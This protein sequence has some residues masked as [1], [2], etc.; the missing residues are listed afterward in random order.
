MTAVSVTLSGSRRAPARERAGSGYSLRQRTRTRA[1]SRFAPG[2]AATVTPSRADPYPAP[3]SAA[4][5]AFGELGERIAERWLRR[6]R[7]ARAS[8]RRFRSGHRDIDL[9]VERDGVVAFVEVKARRGDRFGGSGGGGQLA[10][11]EGVGVVRRASGS[12]ATAGRTTPTGSTWSGCSSRASACGSGTSRT[13][14]PLHR[15]GLISGTGLRILFGY[16]VARFSGTLMSAWPEES[17]TN[18]RM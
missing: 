1:A 10:E 18:E 5:Q 17:T 9:V 3:M 13:H 15:F 14:S 11:A 16:R 4:R 6:A 12:T 8:Q 7:V 2:R